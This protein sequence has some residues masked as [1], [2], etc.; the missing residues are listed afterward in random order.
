MSKCTISEFGITLK[1]RDVNNMK[2]KWPHL[3][4]NVYSFRLT[5]DQTIPINLKLLLLFF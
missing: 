4:R 2:R 1:N 5:L 3:V